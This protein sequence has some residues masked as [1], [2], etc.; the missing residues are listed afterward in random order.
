MVYYVLNGEISAFDSV[1]AF[2][3]YAKYDENGNERGFEQ[4]TREEAD[5]IIAQA[6]ADAAEAREAAMTTHERI[7][8]MEG[9]AKSVVDIEC[10]DPKYFCGIGFVNGMESVRRF[11]THPDA[12]VL[13]EWADRVWAQ[14]QAWVE[15]IDDEQMP[16]D[17]TAFTTVYIAEHLP[18]VNP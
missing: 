18:K 9:L 11:S 13:L 14:V 1:D 4:V 6:Q 7:R 16:V 17:P 5:A 3:Q 8:R 15:S 2:N 10:K 12:L